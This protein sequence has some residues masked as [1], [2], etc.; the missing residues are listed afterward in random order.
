MT[1]KPTPRDLDPKFRDAEIPDDNTVTDAN[2]EPNS[3]SA[4]DARDGESLI[5]YRERYMDGNVQM[6]REHGPMPVSEW[7]AYQEE[8]GF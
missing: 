8:H 6:E 4:D 5:V 7:P 3:K 1:T 2:T